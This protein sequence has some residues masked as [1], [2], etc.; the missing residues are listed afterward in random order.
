V[1]GL[2]GIAALVGLAAAAVSVGAAAPAAADTHTLIQGSGSFW[3]NNAVD[4][5]IADVNLNGSQVVYTPNGSS[6]GKQ[7]FANR[8]SDFA[9][10]DVPYLGYDPTNGGTDSSEGREYGDI[11]IAA[12][13]LTFPYHLTVNG[14]LVRSLRL[15]GLT[16]AKI[17]TGQIANWD[18]SAITKENNG[19]RLPSLRI[20][21]VVQSEGTGV[22]Y[23]FTTYLADRYPKVWKAFAGS[24]QPTQYY[25]IVGGQIH[26]NGSASAM[27][28]IK[29][30]AGNGAIGVVEYSFALSDNYPVAS[31]EN[32]AGYFVPPVQY[33]V[34]IALR[35]ATIDENPSDANYMRPNLDPVFRS[36]DR[37]AYP[38]SFYSS[39]LIPTSAT[40]DKMT[41]AKRQT[42]ADYAYYAICQGQA[43]VGAIGYAPLPLNLVQAG[44]AQIDRL[45]AAE[46]DPNVDLTGRTIST[47]NNPT[48]LKA[49][50]T[51]DYLGSIAPEPA[52]CEK[53][54]QGPCAVRTIARLTVSKRI[55]KSGHVV[56]FHGRLVDKSETGAPPHALVYLQRRR[57]H[58]GWKTIGKR[59]TSATGTV[60]MRKRP[61]STARYRLVDVEPGSDR[62]ISSAVQVKVR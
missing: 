33:N 27:N 26:Q 53:H 7:D 48:F 37:R 3:A 56:A 32:Q 34:A 22:T 51:R 59:K 4:Q 29:S 30:S 2:R 5:W 61:T 31:L 47:C 39:M 28:Y 23:D 18:D 13:A 40:D 58:H 12:G 60:T 1:R 45:G 14:K 8:T 24:T 54:G 15:S 21:P 19:V 62:P 6:A 41:T 55:V 50:L 20:T 57:P 43:E 42:I 35:N 52:A 36:T 25:P 17:F 46:A 49:D 9:V 16:V 10:T 44:F 38:L 11:P